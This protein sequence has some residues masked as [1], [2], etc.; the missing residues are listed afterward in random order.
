MAQQLLAAWRSEAP[1]ARSYPRP[2]PWQALDR[3]VMR[4][5][6]ERMG[7]QTVHISTCV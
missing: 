1:M 2:L 6:P 3:A 4:K 5:V 7:E